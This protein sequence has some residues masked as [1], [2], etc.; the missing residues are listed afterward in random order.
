MNKLIKS[1]IIIALLSG[2]SVAH[3]KDE[4]QVKTY[5]NVKLEVKNGDIIYKMSENKFLPSLTNSTK[6]V[7]TNA[8]QSIGY[9]GQGY[10]VAVIDTGVDFSHSFLAGRKA[11]EACFTA[12]GSCPN[13]TNQMIG[14][15]SAR[16]VHFHGTHVA[17][18]IAGSNSNMRGIAPSA[19]IL[20]IN[21]FETDLSAN[22][23]SIISA[24]E[25]VN[26][27]RA[28]YNIVSVNLSLGTSR[29]WT[30]TCD[31]IS[32]KLTTIIHTLINNKVAV[33][34]AAGNSYSYGMANP[35]CISR[36]TSVAAS[37]SDK[38]DITEFSNISNN[39]T[40]AAPGYKINSSVLNNGYKEVSGT[41]MSTP[42]VAGAFALYNS[43]KPN[44]TVEQQVT[45]FQTNCPKAYDVPTKISVCRLDFTYVATGQSTAPPT[46]TIP[47]P[48]VTTPPVTTP[49]PPV[50]TPVPPVTTPVPPVTTPVPPVTTT[51]PPLVYGTML[52][53]PRLNSVQRYKN[54][55][56]VINY[57]D[58]VYS[59][60]LIYS[61]L[62]ICN[63]FQYLFLP[64]AGS[65]NHSHVIQ[66]FD[67]V[68][69]SCS[70]RAVDSSNVYGPATQNVPIN[71]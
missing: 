66:D 8:L 54:N 47:N 35:A 33:V 28:Q 22:E 41:S 63:D 20:G 18:I 42:H 16:P 2:P 3:A 56:V 50:T 15:G 57:T 51:N 39:T 19:K 64:V 12:A 61:Y 65:T 40:F 69:T 5:K 25:Y 46:T 10:T 58:P 9:S 13:G 29:M 62:L 32:P 49:V 71:K 21:V 67:P 27:V 23:E 59:K 37:Y 31:L 38:D 6:R 55:A 70:L 17:G 48:P 30:S 11:G 1:I 7:N 44:L 68:S 43:F 60:S 52:G 45:N 26:S 4:D 14:D 36:V 24:L 53:K 34:A